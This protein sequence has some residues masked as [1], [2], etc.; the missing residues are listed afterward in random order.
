MSSENDDQLN[1][2]AMQYVLGEMS[3]SDSNAFEDRLADD[4]AACEAVA[5][6]SRMRLVLRAALAE[7]KTA[8]RVTQNVAASSRRSWLV[9][10]TTAV[11]V[12]LFL[13]T[14]FLLLNGN[15][16]KLAR[17]SR[18]NGSDGAVA[19]LFSRWQ[20]GTTAAEMEPVDSDDDLQ[21]PLADVAVP[22]WLL[23]GLSIE[24]DGVV[25]GQT[26]ELKDN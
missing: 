15:N 10:G 9:V 11:A 24:K 20:A 17:L 19:E 12:C 13:G 25:E 18:A 22:E 5:R 2:L 16:S 6:A 14:T 8:V 23:A 7:P 1:W 4:L 21:E 3:E 26:D